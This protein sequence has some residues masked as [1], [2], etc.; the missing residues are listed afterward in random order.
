MDGYPLGGHH[1]AEIAETIRE[2][3]GASGKKATMP[4]N[5]PGV[6][7]GQDL[8]LILDWAQSFDRAQA[9]GLHLTEPDDHGHAH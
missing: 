6:V 3:L 1:S 8:V 9:A 4:R 5:D 2:V 7:Q